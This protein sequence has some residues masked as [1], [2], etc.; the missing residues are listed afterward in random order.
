MSPEKVCQDCGL[1]NK[2]DYKGLCKSCYNKLWLSHNPDKLPHYRASSKAWRKKN[3]GRNCFHNAKWR[4]S[5]KRAMPPWVNQKDVRSVYDNRPI[6]MHV[7]HIVPL[8]NPMV[9]GLHVPWNLQYLS[10]IQN[11]QKRNKFLQTDSGKVQN[12]LR[13]D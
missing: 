1:I 8:T 5:V 4:K 11:S 7:D 2:S 13:E 12:G 6:G 10:P 9:C 3:S